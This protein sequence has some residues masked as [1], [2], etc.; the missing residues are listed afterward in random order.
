MDADSAATAQGYRTPTSDPARG[1]RN[2][3][4]RMVVRWQLGHLGRRAISESLNGHHNSNLLLT[5]NDS[6][7]RLVGE[8]PPDPPLVKLRTPLRGPSVVMRT[9]RDEAR[10]LAAVRTSIPEVPRCLAEFG[11]MS[12][13]TF[14]PGAPLSGVAEKGKPVGEATLRMIAEVL[15]RTVATPPDALPPLPAGWPEDKDTD[16]FLRRLAAFCEEHVYRRNHAEFGGLFDAL[17][18]PHDAMTRFLERSCARPLTKRPFGL[19]HTD[20]HRDN[21][22]VLPDGRLFV[23]DW[24]LA[25]WGDPLHELATHLVRMGYTG[26]E[27]ARM[28]EL[29]AEALTRRGLSAMTD[30]LTADLPVYIAFE[31]A[32]SL[33]ADVI[34]AAQALR[35][36]PGDMPALAVREAVRGIRGAL[37]RA[38]GPIGLDELDTFPRDDDR[39]EA[40]LRSWHAGGRQDRRLRRPLPLPGIPAGP[41]AVQ[42]AL[43]G[44]PQWPTGPWRRARRAGI[45]QQAAQTVRQRS[46]RP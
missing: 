1:A 8:E 19:L 3:V 43:L 9:W 33:Y 5:W 32:Q 12:L 20:I 40:A 17:G 42:A 11:R 13:H 44:G 10:V 35:R 39:I 14:A 15:A 45:R 23:L 46:P 29:W 41:A 31:H 37:D 25:T 7:S 34:R 28:R 21:L 18:V 2:L 27:S 22:V 26:V 6:M 24:E 38:A 30:G 4:H 16:G 36:E